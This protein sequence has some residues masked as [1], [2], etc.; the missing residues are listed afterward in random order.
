M[1][2]AT[3]GRGALQSSEV[4]PALPDGAAG[5]HQVNVRVA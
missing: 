3:D 4:T 2:R 5:Y 1:V